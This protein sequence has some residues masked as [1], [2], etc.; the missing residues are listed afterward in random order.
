MLRNFAIEANGNPSSTANSIAALRSQA[1][2]LDG[3]LDATALQLGLKDARR[4]PQWRSQP[5]ALRIP[6]RIGE[7]GP[8]TYQND[9]VLQA[10]LGAERTSKIQLLSGDSSRLLNVQRQGAIYAYEILNFVDGKRTIADI[11]DAVSAEFSPL[12]LAVVADYLQACEEAKIITYHAPLA[13]DSGF[14]ITAARAPAPWITM[15]GAK[16]I[17]HPI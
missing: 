5:M 16:G 14:G 4:T 2:I 10:R 13:R 1:A 9:D 6:H 15:N 11:R 12:P 8:L 7:F 3:W 17:R